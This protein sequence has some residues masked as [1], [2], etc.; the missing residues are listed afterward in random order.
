VIV[1][2]TETDHRNSLNVN[3]EINLLSS[4]KCTVSHRR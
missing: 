4:E 3:K 1:L 2:I